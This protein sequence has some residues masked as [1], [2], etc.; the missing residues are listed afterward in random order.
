MENLENNIEQKSRFSSQKLEDIA[1]RENIAKVDAAIEGIKP[2]LFYENFITE[3]KA[4]RLKNNEIRQR[5]IAM[6]KAENG[7]KI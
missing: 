5:F 2:N 7:A 3:L 1:W 6:V 4:K